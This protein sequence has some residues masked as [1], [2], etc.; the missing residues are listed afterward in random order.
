MK[1]YTVKDIAEQSGFSKDTIRRHADEGRIPCLRDINQWRVF[2]EKSIDVA[3]I[4]AGTSVLASS[5]ND[6][7]E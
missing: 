7:S 6:A 2:N 4:L 5:T 3:K 1:R